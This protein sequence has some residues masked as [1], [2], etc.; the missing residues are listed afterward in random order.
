MSNG[1]VSPAG[2]RGQSVVET[3]KSVVSRPSWEQSGMG[4][5]NGREGTSMDRRTLILGLLGLLGG[6]AAAPAI[7]TAASSVEAAP[8]PE[9]LPSTPE[10]APEPTSPPAATEADLE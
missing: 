5:P 10:S 2:S 7:I 1:A 8:L 9:A 3:M 4:Y 6:L